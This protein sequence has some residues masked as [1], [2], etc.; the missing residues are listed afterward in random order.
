[1][2]IFAIDT[3]TVSA[4]VAVLNDDVVLYETISTV[5]KHHGEGL[6]PMIDHVVAAAGIRFPDVGLFAVTVGPGSF[7]GLRVGVSTVKG[8]ALMNNTPVAAVSTLDALAAGVMPHSG[9]MC[10]L[11]DAGRG[12]V[13]AALY[14]G[15][16]NGE[17]VKMRDD[18]LVRPEPFLR[19]LTDG[20]VL[21]VGGGTIAYDDTIRS[22]MGARC[23]IA[24]PRCH[25]IRGSSV[26]AMGLK[27]FHEGDILKNE[28]L[29][30][31]YFRKSYAEENRC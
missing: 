17:A 9:T 4:S 7:T 12:D 8:L 19:S 26:G 20:T 29:I 28:D 14:K 6:M 30:P 3:A 21:F 2:I 15:M 13:Y 16:G 24:P 27:M 11:L 18:V 25:V 1:M 23:T 5:R 31:R 22:I 10:A